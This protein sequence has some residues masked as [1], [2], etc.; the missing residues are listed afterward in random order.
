M[1]T[2]KQKF[3]EEES[4]TQ[5]DGKTKWY[6]TTKVPLVLDNRSDYVLGVAVDITLDVF[7]ELVE[8]L[9]PFEGSHAF[10]VSNKGLIAG[11]PN[12]ELLMTDI[13]ELYPQDEL[14]YNITK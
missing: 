8:E 10:L 4:I 7:Q 11:H 13:K 1:S 2:G 12:K 5:H 6:Q 9:K 14:K 3:I